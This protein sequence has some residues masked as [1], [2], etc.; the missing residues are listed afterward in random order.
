MR[1][2]KLAVFIGRFQP[3]HNS[4]LQVVEKALQTAENLLIIL[5]SAHAAPSIKN[6]FSVEQRKQMIISGLP[7]ELAQ[8]VIIREV[9]DYYYSDN[10]W[11]SN[12]QSIVSQHEDEDHNVVLITNYKDE[13]SYYLDLFPQWHKQPAWS[14]AKM[15]ATS[16]RETMF[17]RWCGTEDFK[18]YLPKGT[19]TWICENFIGSEAHAQMI[20]EMEHIEKYR[21]QWADA[22]FPVTFVTTDTIVVKSGHVLMVRRRWEPGKGLLALPGGFIKQNERIE[23]CAIRELKEETKI[24]V[25][26]MILRSNIKDVHVFDHPGRSTRG[27]T[28]THAYFIDLGK[29]DLP[30]VRGS[31]DASEALWVPLM[32]LYKMEDKIYEDH[33]HIVNYF[34][35]RQY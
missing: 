24:Q 2:Y 8:R 22:P 31:D 16:V 17:N 35:N 30:K 4:H 1:E 3:F 19:H 33:F 14:D 26:H 9:R 6:P 11:V 5:G 12:V 34:I 18:K 21:R 20:S 13:S 25:N 7:P 27:R 32:D 29:G 23:N 15:D 28:I 10:M